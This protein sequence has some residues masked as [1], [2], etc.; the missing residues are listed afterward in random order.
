MQT[1]SAQEL[2]STYMHLNHLKKYHAVHS[3]LDNLAGA[4]HRQC[5][6]K[7]VSNL[8]GWQRDRRA[9]NMD[10]RLPATVESTSGSPALQGAHRQWQRRLE[11]NKL[12]GQVGKHK[13][14]P[15]NSFH[16]GTWHQGTKTWERLPF[17]KPCCSQIWPFICCNSVS[18]F[19][20]H[21]L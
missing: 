14:Q 15:A 11:R 21:M 2:L 17:S 8:P 10:S 7:R 18:S 1:G 4:S 19:C 6:L 3:L 12:P 20:P 5:S 13:P 16:F 9:F